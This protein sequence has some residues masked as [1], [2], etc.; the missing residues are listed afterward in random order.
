M[1][2]VYILSRLLLMRKIPNRIDT[3]IDISINVYISM[4][5]IESVSGHYLGSIP[6]ILI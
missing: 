2:I 3:Q 6:I 4:I 5:K 1:N